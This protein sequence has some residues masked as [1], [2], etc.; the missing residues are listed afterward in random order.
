MSKAKK[1]AKSAAMIMFFTL[2]S[3]FLGFVREVLIANKFGSGWE[4]DTYFIAMTA[5]TMVMT[6]VGTAINTTVIPL[7][8]EIEI[9]HGKDRKIDYMN[10]ILNVVFFLAIILI[11]LGWILSP[12]IIKIIARGFKGEQFDLAVKLNRVGLPIILFMG[13]TFIF[14]GFLESSE[15]F[16]APAAMSLPF[17]LIYIVFL[18]GFSN[19]Y[20]IVALMVASV[21]ATLSQVIIQLP[22]AK[23][24]GY[25]YK[26]KIDL[27]DRYLKKALIL[28]LPVLIGSAINEINVIVDRALASKLAKGSISALTY[29]TRINSIV[30]G[31]FVMAIATVV[32]PMLS[33]ESNKEDNMDSLKEIMGYGINTILIITIPAMI[34]I[35]ILAEPFV[36]IFFQR[37]A[38]DARA[39]IMT[40][41][42]V[43]YYSIGMVA[44]ALNI[45]LNRVYYSL[46]DTRTPMINAAISVGINIG[47]SLILVKL[48]GHG[49]LALATSIASISTT[50]LLINS[51]R[52]KLGSIDIKNY[53]T[54]FI[55]SIIASLIMGIIVYSIY[56][57]LFP[58]AG[59]R[60]ILDL[61]IFLVSVGIGVAIYFGLCYLFKIEEIKMIIDK[62]KARIKK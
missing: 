16:A 21:I 47:L 62:I 15:S 28:T 27:K 29:A 17:N 57:G 11:A 32:F 10:N 30:L 22:S 37:G 35:I 58:L 51:L 23:K 20:G 49:G 34:G 39:T 53:L 41:Q 2:A 9:K 33:K 3:K 48:M 14:K 36:R 46:Q 43:I 26:F 6:M 54:C 1:A 50:L 8:S 7:F 38:F 24:I 40:S 44:M 45:L 4:T 19:K 5:T 13:I 52:K 25:K 56:N 12:T 59:G 60:K 31:V 18:L 55:K 61:L 42:A